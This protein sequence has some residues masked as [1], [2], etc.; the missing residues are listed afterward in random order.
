MIYGTAGFTAA[1]SVQSLRAHGID[2]GEVLVTGA[3]GG[4]GCTAVAILS[5]LGYRVVAATGKA[6]AVEWLKGI[7][8]SEVV[9]REA[10]TDVT[11]KPLLK[12]RWD[13]VVETVGGPVLSTVIRA[14][15]YRGIVTCCGNVGGAELPLSVYPFILRGVTLAGI[16]SAQC[17]MPQRRQIWEKLAGDWKPAGLAKLARECTL[18]QL[19]SEIDRTLAGRQWGRVVVRL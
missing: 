1:Q 3:T 17:P 8:A 10:V 7:G 11:G 12:G 2:S 9:G 6:A 5:Q 14:M 13:A 4:V 15:Q 18:D 19:S 16:D